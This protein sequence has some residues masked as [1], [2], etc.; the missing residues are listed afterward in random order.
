M[1]SASG[2]SF[3]IRIEARDV[4]GQ[5]VRA[6]LANF[7][8]FSKQIAAKPVEVKA[9][10]NTSA[11]L[12]QVLGGY[13]ALAKTL[14]QR[15][16]EVKA[17][18]KSK[19]AFLSARENYNGLR[20]AMRPITLTVQ[21][22]RGGL[23]LLRDIQ[24]GLLPTLHQV[25][26][27]VDHATGIEPVLKTFE[28]RS[29]HVGQNA[30]YAARRL[31]AAAFGTL[32]WVDAM[33]EA[34]RA[35]SAGIPEGP[36]NTIF[37]Y[38]ALKAAG[39]RGNAG[40]LTSQII[41]GLSRSDRGAIT[42]LKDMGIDVR[43]IADDYDRI[44][45]A[46]AFDDLP[47]AQ[48]RLMIMSEATR[49]MEE[50]IQKFALSGRDINFIWAAIKTQVGD[51]V[52]KFSA[53]VLKSDAV[54]KGAQALKDILG[55]AVEHLEKGGSL[56]E[57]LFGG[58][59]GDESGGLLGGV[60][61]GLLDA[62]EAFIDLLNGA[63]PFIVGEIREAFD[64]KG[65]K[66]WAADVK[67]AF[68]PLETLA[69]DI[70]AAFFD[71]AKQIRQAIIDGLSEALAQ[72]FPGLFTTVDQ[73][74]NVTEGPVEFIGQGYDK[75]GIVGAA[76]NF[77][78]LLISE[79]LRR[80]GILPGGGPPPTQKV[81]SNEIAPSPWIGDFPN[82]RRGG[83]PTNPALVL[84]QAV[85]A[86]AMGATA[87]AKSHIEQWREAFAAAH[88]PP[89]AP[90]RPSGITPADFALSQHGR[91][92]LLR[93]QQARR[94]ELDR[95]GRGELGLR[96]QA[97]IEVSA[98]ILKRRKQG[99]SVTPGERRELLRDKLAQLERARAAPVRERLGQIEKDLTADDLAREVRRITTERRRMGL[100]S[101]TKRIRAEIQEEFDRGSKFSG[102]TPADAHSV[103]AMKAAADKIM[104]KIDAAT[105][106]I[107][108]LASSFDG[109]GDQ[110]QAARGKA[111]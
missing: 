60:K 59:K 106:A 94:H 75:G 9:K 45:G 52:D 11:V 110:L 91:S 64:L 57:L 2:M 30:D 10:D 97:A 88:P 32:G 77:N 67:T 76:S 82:S 81:G 35:F 47:F 84:A 55:G 87:A 18:D 21:L 44:K 53:W 99:Y 29:G 69:V 65:W 39:E 26:N 93:E 95:I 38:A 71:G 109:A 83:A 20:R 40:Q 22:A 85:A 8:G 104:S 89:P 92:A 14:T 37:R 90:P 111:A 24:L 72:H 41:G 27:F 108:Q 6:A 56:K 79:L 31:Q 107:L 13:N 34:N 17:T 51:A 101:D 58:G 16:A 86:S 43:D 63:T 50:E 23:G 46:G 102:K 105:N 73:K 61:A 100:N 28:Q 98:D 62:G 3:G 68:A 7:L 33:A 70:V 80:L 1:S 15:P 12:R 42:V 25:K 4:S 66:A 48:R 78:V 96:R 54:K 103:N 74:G 5:A 19:A 49:R 36:L